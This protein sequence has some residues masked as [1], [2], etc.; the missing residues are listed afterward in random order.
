MAFLS[1]AEIGELIAQNDPVAQIDMLA[2]RTAGLDVVILSCGP[3]LSDYPPAEL[4]RLLSGR[5]V[6]AVKQAYDVVPEAV[7]F[8]ILN[9]WNSQKYD[10]SRRRPFIIREGAA[11][12]PPVFGPADLT[13]LVERPRALSEQ[14]ARKRNF[15]DFR[16]DVTLTRP[17]GPGVLYEIGFY[18][19]QHL[20]ARR[21][22]TLGWDVGVKSSSVMPHFYD[23]PDR[24]KT[25]ILA[26]ASRLRTQEERNRFLHDNGVLYNKPRIVPDE[27]ETCIDAS[28]PWNDYLAAA[29]IELVVVS[30]NSLA[31]PAIRR[32]RLEEL[33]AG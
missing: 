25:E 3:S 21:I 10:Y 33:F 19:A 15:A 32:S 29:G 27:V 16:F 23:R 26:E 17:W 13:L 8:Q 12:D 14:L 20:G 22:V 1:N 31:S 11:G 2:G 18:L 4:R 7:D 30:P 5:C 9:T 24:H 28:G 6:V